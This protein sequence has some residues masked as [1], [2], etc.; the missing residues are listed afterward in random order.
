M[1][2]CALS[3][4]LNKSVCFF[5]SPQRHKDFYDSLFAVCTDAPR[6]LLH[7]SR[8]AIRAALGSFCDRGV[9]QLPLPLSMKKYLL[10]EPEG[11]LY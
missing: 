2:E 8:C 4:K 10:L 3:L 7:L 1:T 11:I 9:A 6:S 5:L